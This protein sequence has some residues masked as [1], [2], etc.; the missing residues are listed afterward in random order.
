MQADLKLWAN[1]HPE[2]SC[3]R[4]P[5]VSIDLNA[6]NN[7]PIRAAHRRPFR[8][9]IFVEWGFAGTESSSLESTQCPLCL[10]LASSSNQSNF[11]ALLVTSSPWSYDRWVGLPQARAHRNRLS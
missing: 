1:Q 11:S 9:S 3:N 5:P 4:Q 8:S 10:R 7:Q 2:H 6:C